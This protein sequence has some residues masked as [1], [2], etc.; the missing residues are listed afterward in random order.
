MRICR[1]RLIEGPGEELGPL[2]QLRKERSDDERRFRLL[3]YIDPKT[4]ARWQQH[5]ACDV[6]L[7]YV[8]A[9]ENNIEA[10][11]FC[12]SGHC[13]PDCELSKQTPERIAGRK[14][15]A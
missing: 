13:K 10:S 15:K 3:R 5:A 4:L 9:G 11:V 14:G 2:H 7:R 12:A 1:S 6:C 8:A